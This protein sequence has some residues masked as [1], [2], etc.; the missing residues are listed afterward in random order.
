MVTHQSINGLALLA[1][2]LMNEMQRAALRSKKEMPMRIRVP[3][4]LI[5]EL[6]GKVELCVCFCHI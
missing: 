3:I 4:L 1:T 6:L 5:A 2:R